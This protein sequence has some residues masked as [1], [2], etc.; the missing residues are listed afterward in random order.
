MTARERSNLRKE[1]V[2]DTSHWTEVTEQLR[3]A[4]SRGVGV[5]AAREVVRQWERAA[6]I[7]RHNA[8]DDYWPEMARLAS[9]IARVGM[10]LAAAY[11]LALS[12]DHVAATK[13]PATTDA[14][15]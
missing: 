14:I 12:L 4:V 8:R 9:S 15:E 7:T 6:T 3:L 1:I 13:P 5:E 2:S 10:L 11:G